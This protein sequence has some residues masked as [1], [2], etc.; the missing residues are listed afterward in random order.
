MSSTS[1]SVSAKENSLVYFGL[2]TS[3][4]G[5]SGTSPLWVSSEQM[6]V[7]GAPSSNRQDS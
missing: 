2:S 5:L 3:L 6:I 4:S 1:A 7:I